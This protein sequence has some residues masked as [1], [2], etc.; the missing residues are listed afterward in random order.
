MT[1]I[2]GSSSHL[3]INPERT[4][5]TAKGKIANVL[6]K[7]DNFLWPSRCSPYAIVRAN[8]NDREV[9]PR[10]YIP[11]VFRECVRSLSENIVEKFLKPTNAI[12]VTK[13]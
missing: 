10:V 13:L 12:G 6:Y 1:P 4:K 5:G 9:T 8:T 11:V 7:V 2:P 3:H